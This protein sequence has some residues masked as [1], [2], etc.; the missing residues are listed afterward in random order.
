MAKYKYTMKVKKVVI[1]DEIEVTVVA[2]DEARAKWLAENQAE[3]ENYFANCGVESTSIY[4]AE[5]YS[6]SANPVEDSA[7]F[8][9]AVAENEAVYSHN[10]EIEK[11]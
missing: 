11:K 5:V 8:D 2:E 1:Y 6:Y 3:R 10:R 9:A 7:Q 4:H